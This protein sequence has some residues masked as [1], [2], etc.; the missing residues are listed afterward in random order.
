MKKL[1]LQEIQLEPYHT[2][3]EGKYEEFGVLHAGNHIPEIL[4]YP[5]ETVMERF[6]TAGIS[7]EV[8]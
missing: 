4:N 1:N 8:A 6:H 3:G 5:V 2:L 7:C